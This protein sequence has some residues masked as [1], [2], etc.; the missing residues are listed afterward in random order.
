MLKSYCEQT[1]TIDLLD[2]SILL[3]GTF[4]LGDSNLLEWVMSSVCSN[5]FREE[6]DG[7]KFKSDFWIPGTGEL[8]SV[9]MLPS[10]VC[11]AA[12]YSESGVDGREFGD[13]DLK[14]VTTNPKQRRE[15]VTA[16][17]TYVFRFGF[18]FC[19]CVWDPRGSIF[20]ILTRSCFRTACMTAYVSVIEC[21]MALKL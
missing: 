6:D 3:D 4:L 7:E 19:I 9:D 8:P 12:A 21:S 15:N 5:S 13:D 18:G 1:T 20:V 14:C 16:N 10:R 2:N 11:M 17:A